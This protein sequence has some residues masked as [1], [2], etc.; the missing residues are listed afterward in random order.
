M[1]RGTLGRVLIVEDEALLLDII[2]TEMED[3][4]FTVIR[5]TDADAALTVLRG[6]DV[7]D[8]LFT[9]I[10]L[11]GSMNGWRLGETARQLRRD[12]PIM[13]ATGYTDQALAG[14]DRRRFFQKPYRI[15]DVIQTIRDIVAA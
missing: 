15:A 12:L 4:G 2:A 11:P 14:V 9:D 3:E 7:I 1:T 13:Y 10:R 8:V 5:A 6:P